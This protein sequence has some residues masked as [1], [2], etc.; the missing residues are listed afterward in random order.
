MLVTTIGV[1]RQ[2]FP[3][4][5]FIVFSYSPK[6]DRS[7][8]QDARIK[9]V[10]ATPASMVFCIFPWAVLISFL[11]LLHI[12]FPGSFPIQVI[13]ELCRCDAM[14]DI[15]G[16]SFVDGRELFLPYN[17]LSIWLAMMLN[18]PVV[19]LAQ[20]LGPFTSSINR[21]TAKIFLPRCAKIFSRGDTTSR[22][23][24]SINISNFARAAD[25]AFLYQSEFSLSKENED[26]VEPLM[27][28]LGR[29]RAQGNRIIIISPSS[30]V[31][32]KS[33]KKGGDYIGQ[34]LH[35]VS[36]LD[37]ENTHFLFLPNSTRQVSS[38][39]RNNDIFI[40][41]LL[42]H[43][44][45]TSL[46]PERFSKTHWVTWDVNTASLRGLMKMANLIITSRF[47]AMVS[48]LA[49]GIPT[50]VIGWS[51]KY[52]E[53][54]ADFGMEHFAADFEDQRVNL[55]ALAEELIQ[56]ESTIR[57]QLVDRLGNVQALSKTQ[58]EY[59]EKLWN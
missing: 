59:V 18:I 22:N 26:M 2:S 15:G 33:V 8:V 50:L 39:P 4:S 42:M 44:A 20:A 41:D 58:F 46:T 6:R 27:D 49:L 17:I 53:T 16:I 5:E 19:K 31:Y 43:R 34:L 25:I 7:L 37:N 47:H 55:I 35:L 11:R 10:S 51:H 57:Q 48:G 28:E 29:I 14:L 45:L 13:K 54:L 30:L 38:K 12:P 56:D 40:I 1:L 21:L 36:E 23:L 52:I 3:D 24:Q 32:Q 9:V